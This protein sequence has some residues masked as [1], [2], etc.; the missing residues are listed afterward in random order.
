M[1]ATKYKDSGGEL[2]TVEQTQA[3]SNLGM[4]TVKKLA[5]DAGA[6][7]RIGKCYRI[8]RRLFFDYIEKVYAE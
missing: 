4:H 8:N 1:N 3:L 5:A 2:L 7:R 6:V